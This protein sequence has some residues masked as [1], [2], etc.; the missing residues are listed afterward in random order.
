MSQTCCYKVKEYN[1]RFKFSLFF[2][3]NTHIRAN[4]SKP[5]F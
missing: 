3:V 5:M 2:A 1:S 4:G